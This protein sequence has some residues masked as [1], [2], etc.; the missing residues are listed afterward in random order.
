MT[1][2]S[3]I[4]TENKISRF[5]LRSIHVMRAGKKVERESWLGLIPDAASET[6]QALEWEE[7]ALGVWHLRLYWSAHELVRIKTDAGLLTVALWSLGKGER[8][9]DGLYAA[10]WLYLGETGHAPDVAWVKKLPAGAP[11]NL[12]VDDEIVLQICEAEWAPQR[13]VAVGRSERSE[14]I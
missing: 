10:A 2:N 13:C 11:S 12:K 7:T 5:G 4:L 8:M 14:A 1:D 9:S 3:E 6:T